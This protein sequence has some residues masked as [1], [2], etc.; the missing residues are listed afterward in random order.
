[1][2]DIQKEKE[3]KCKEDGKTLFF[4]R[5]GNIEIK[6][7]GRC[8]KERIVPLKALETDENILKV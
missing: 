8:K 2:S 5:D 1:M 7:R 6:C 3:V 4:V